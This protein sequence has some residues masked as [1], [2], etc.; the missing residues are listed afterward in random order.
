MVQMLTQQPMKDYRHCTWLHWMV[1]SYANFESQTN[2]WQFKHNSQWIRVITATIHVKS[3]EIA[4]FCFRSWAIGQFSHWEKSRCKYQRP[5]WPNSNI[6]SHSRR[7]FQYFHAYG[8]HF[9]TCKYVIS[10]EFRI[11]EFFSFSF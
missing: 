2:H 10:F 11:R 5:W 3:I 4:N 6:C 8:A 7:Y 1:N 9:I